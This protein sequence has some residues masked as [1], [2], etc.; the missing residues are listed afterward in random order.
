MAYSNLVTGQQQA[1]NVL[2]GSGL[3]NSGYADSQRV[4]M[5][6]NY[7]TSINEN[8]LAR[9]GALRDIGLARQQT[10]LAGQ[11]D[12]ASINANYNQLYANFLYQKQQDEAAAQTEQQQT[13][14]SNAYNA[15]EYGDFSQLKALGIDT[16]SAEKLYKEKVYS[17]LASG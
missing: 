16:S 10:E 5:Q 11:S 14:L 9:V 8:E 3:Y 15:A 2:A 17:S 6:N 1:A 13:A 12:I 7:G 4:Q